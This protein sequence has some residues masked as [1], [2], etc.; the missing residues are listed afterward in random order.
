M[1]NRLLEASLRQRPAV[2][3]ATA[4]LVAV[5]GWAALRLPLDA[6]PDIT[7][8]QVQ[9]NVA[10]AGLAP[11][12]IEMQVTYPLENQMSGIPGM[13]ELRSLSKSGLAQ[14]TMIFEDGTDLYR[15]RQLVSERLQQV[16]Q[17]LPP[18]LTPKLAPIATGLGEI[19][20]YGVD[21]RADATNKPAARRDQLMALKLI[22]DYQ[23]K[24]LLRQT[25]GGAEVNTSGGY[26][27]VFVIQPDPA[28]LLSVG[29]TLPDLAAKVAENTRNA[30][31]GLVE[32]GGEQITIRANSR[33]T[34]ADQLAELPLKFGA[35]VQP[36]L[37]R[38][39]ATVGIGTGFRIGASTENGE[40]SL[41]GAAIMTAGEN[42][43]L[44][45]LA[46]AEKLREIQPKLP[47]GVEIHTLYDR[48][49]LV[50]RTI[51]TVMT[52]LAEGA[53]LVVVVLFLLLGNVRGA[54]IVAAAI[55]L[56]ML[57]AMVGMVEL[58]IPG[59]LMSLGAI[60]F[61]LIIDGAVVMVEN[62]LRRLGEKQ[63]QLGRALTA[64]ER[65]AG[66][67]T[68]AKEVARP[69]FFGVL[70]ITV[71][72]VPI[73]AL[74]GIEGKMFKPMAL[75]VML[76]LGGALVLAVTLMPVLCSLFLTGSRRG[77]DNGRARLSQRA[78]GVSAPSDGALRTA[79]PYPEPELPPVSTVTGR[80]LAAE[81]SQM[82]PPLPA[83]EGRGEGERVDHQTPPV[84]H[85][86][87]TAGH[88][89]NW[90]VRQTKRLYTPL[91]DFGLRHRAW[92][93]LPSLALCVVAALLFARL[94][95]EFIP[96][97]D[98][99][100]GVFQ[101]VK[102]QSA[103]LQSCLEIQKQSER[104]LR[105]EF[106]E[107]KV[108]FSRMGAAEIATDPMDPSD[109][110]TYLMFQPRATWRKE[111]GR[112]IT[113]ERL[114][115]LMQQSLAQKIPVQAILP[116]QPI[117]MRFDEIMAGARA[118]L[119]C[120]IFGDDYATLER[121]AEEV[122]DVLRKIPGAGEVEFDKIGRVPQ[123]EITPDRAALRR[124]NL[125]A[126]DV[127][128]VVET[129]LAGASVGFIQDG[130]RR[131]PI[132]VRLAEEQR[133]DLDLIRR[134]PVGV[135]GGGLLTLGRLATITNLN[136]IGMIKRENAQ[137]LVTL[138]INVR[139]RDTAS[140]V[141]EAQAAVQAQVKFPE[142][143]YPEFGGQ[144]R[145]L[146]KAKQRLLIVV[147]L[148]LA[149]IFVLLF[150]SFGSVRQAALIFVCVPL[151]VTGGV[152]ALWVREMPFTIS[153]AVGFI[154]LSGIAVLNGIMLISFINQLR[155]QGRNLR[156]AV[157]EGTLTRLRPKLMTA[158][159]ASFGFVPM[160]L[161][162][163]AGA[164]VQRPLA[165]VV[166]GGIIT[167]TFLTLVLLPVLYEWMEKRFRPD[168]RSGTVETGPPDA[169]ANRQ[170]SETSH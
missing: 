130:N 117:Q 125:H 164:E 127:N 13:I 159:V 96:Q 99:G 36:I 119:A 35:A 132:V 49:D 43:R 40:E 91:L 83:G 18:G 123:I 109:A 141:A 146:V 163:G 160:A 77:N 118:E 144:F 8:P 70:I 42:S 56:A 140:F 29:L 93:V 22:Q 21:Y 149:F 102:S 131:F 148:A 33:V 19:F 47:P 15:A 27:K 153:A 112:P 52:N 31:G 51:H 17:D 5:G 10:V 30:G 75:V 89:D 79:A 32:L 38:D 66:V 20:Y 82:V 28:R 158:L 48:S 108:V 88:D 94:G 126:D 111:N 110:D 152:F 155:D 106:P 161:A 25:P 115:E 34:H 9:I 168:A 50:N 16:T 65:L 136:Q 100:D 46:V 74:E 105:A 60:D 150:L 95:A 58:R 80:A 86:G 63:R 90:L 137:R 114:M 53:L 37:V 156:D 4:V 62:I 24:P 3:L 85:Q 167:S 23:I 124:Y 45:S 14:V 129:A 116:N 151:A 147:P 59:N 92:I 72:Y 154:A 55:P 41:L 64:P 78:A 166:I 71:V 135:D 69:M 1:L 7:N 122:R 54:L 12:E 76:A 169:P 6:V 120:K 143:Y 133:S 162:T 157:M 104:L 84:E 142:G 26:E 139:G 97:L 98:E 73:L 138:L 61:G 134:L 44:V 68:A 81:R 67:L 165:T 87:S 101:L 57:L 11:E 128:K 2:L 39:V 103:G 113:K 170:P 121:L 107:L 145:N